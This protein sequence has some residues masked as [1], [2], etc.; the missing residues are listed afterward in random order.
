MNHPFPETLAAR[1]HKSLERWM[2][3]KKACPECDQ[4]KARTSCADVR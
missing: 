1:F 2:E 4:N 3:L